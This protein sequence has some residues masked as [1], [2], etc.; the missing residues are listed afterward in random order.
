MNSVCFLV[1]LVDSL[2]TRVVSVETKFSP[3]V[4]CVSLLPL[5]FSVRREGLNRK[6][7]QS[8]RVSITCVEQRNT[9]SVVTVRFESLLE[10]HQINI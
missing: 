10:N 7:K 8:E 9:T 5:K 3:D 1:V 2:L 4:L 6:D